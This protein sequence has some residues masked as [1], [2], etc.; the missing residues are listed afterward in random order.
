MSDLRKVL[1]DARDWLAAQPVPVSG[2]A[3]WYGF[4]NLRTFLN[5]IEADP[6]PSNLERAC[7]ALGRHISDQYGTYKELPTIASLNDK[8]RRIAKAQTW[9]DYKAGPDYKPLD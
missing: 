6:S 1:I 4:N 8:V 3:T 2:S 5:Q 9:Q 7:H